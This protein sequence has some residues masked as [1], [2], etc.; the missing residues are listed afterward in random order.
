MVQVLFSIVQ[1]EQEEEE[2]EGEELEMAAQRK[3]STNE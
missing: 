2:K 1:R 3:L